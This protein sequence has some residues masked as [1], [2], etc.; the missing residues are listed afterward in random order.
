MSLY[1]RMLEFEQG[2]LGQ[3][4][5]TY[6]VPGQPF[7]IKMG[8]NVKFNPMLNLQQAGIVVCLVESMQ[9]A[10]YLRHANVDE[11]ISF[12]KQNKLRSFITTVNIHEGI[13]HC[14]GFNQILLR[15]PN[16]TPFMGVQAFNVGRWIFYQSTPYQF[17]DFL[18]AQ[19]ALGVNP[20]SIQAK[21]LSPFDRSVYRVVYDKQVEDRKQE[22][23]RLEAEREKD[24][25]YKIQKSLNYH[26]ATL[27]GYRKEGSRIRVTTNIPG[28][29]LQEL[30]VDEN[31]VVVNMGI[32]VS[33]QDR[34]FSLAAAPHI[35]AESGQTHHDEDDDY[36]PWDE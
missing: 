3:Q 31:L 16:A 17:S 23:A 6:A 22:E 8:I 2:F 9:T 34:N 7:T 26:G 35:I 33:G 15:I 5:V 14:L 24:I 27:S 21:G 36:D 32:C 30:I 28:W 11:T 20:D 10:R 1:K 25:A 29:G 4:I 19:L 18:S 12:F 13:W